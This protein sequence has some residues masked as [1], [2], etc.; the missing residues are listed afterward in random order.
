VNQ[1]RRQSAGTG[2]YAGARGEMALHAREARGSD[3]M[4]T[5]K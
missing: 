5:L 2:K 1:G 4:F 3:F